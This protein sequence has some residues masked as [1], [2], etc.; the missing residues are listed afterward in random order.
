M[1]GTAPPLRRA[2]RGPGQEWVWDYPRPPRVESVP[3]RLRVV[4]DGKVVAE[5]TRGVRV[6]ET[7][8]APVYYFPPDD[9]RMDLLRTS[10]HSTFCEWKG[11]ATYWTYEPGPDARRI[12]NVAWAYEQ[13]LRGYESM[14]GYLA[15]YAQLVD[16]A[17]VGDERATPQ[18]GRY[19]G[20]WVTSK[21]VGP[22]KGEPGTA[23]W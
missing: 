1:A 21:V 16:E 17:W 13:P 18:P 14:R 4:V 7:A 10:P 2:E 9:V 6:L 3:E 19:Y 20:G 15:F 12:P 11:D 8:G 22:F 23:G 5:T